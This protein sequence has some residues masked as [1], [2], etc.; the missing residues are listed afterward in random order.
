ME[1]LVYKVSEERTQIRIKVGTKPDEARVDSTFDLERVQIPAKPQT[2]HDDLYAPA[3]DRYARGDAR[4]M[5]VTF[6]CL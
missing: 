6:I 3:T 4:C 5:I 1:P 2:R